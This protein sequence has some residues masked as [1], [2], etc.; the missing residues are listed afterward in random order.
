[1]CDL[2]QFLGS[3][4]VEHSLSGMDDRSLR[5]QQRPR[6]LRHGLRVTSLAQT[7]RRGVIEPLRAEITCGHIL[8]D[9]QQ[10]WSR[11]ATPQLGKR[12]PHEFWYPL[13]HVDLFAPFGDGLIAARWIKIR[14]DATPLSC[15]A[16]RQEQN[17]DGFGISL[18]HAAKA[19]FCPWAILHHEDANALAIGD[20]GI[21]VDHVNAGPFLTKDNSPNAGN[22]RSLQ[23]RLIWD[24]PNKVHA[25]HT[26]DIGNGSHTIHSGSP[27]S[28]WLGYGTSTGSIRL[29]W[30]RVLQIPLTSCRL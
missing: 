30:L 27:L 24:A 26:Q 14:V 18:G 10:H 16:S 3:L 9:F 6:R 25:L 4:G 23:Q 13:H 15:H 22:S 20:P 5:R 2:H 11:S 19:V 17:G 7:R 12:P 28:T 29:N 21:A 1:L 8:W